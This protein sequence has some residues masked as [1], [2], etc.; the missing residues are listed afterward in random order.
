[1]N[2]STVRRMTSSYHDRQNPMRNEYGGFSARLFAMIFLIGLVI[3]VG[4]GLGI[5]AYKKYGELTPPVIEVT[6]VPRGIGIAPVTLRFRVSD[7]GSG[8]DQVVLRAQ[9]RGRERQLISR[10]L[11]GALTADEEFSFTGTKSNFQEGVLR[12]EIIAFDRSFWSNR[13]ER[14]VELS[15]DYRKPRIEVVTTQH[16][17]RRGGS[18]LVAYRA[19]DENLALSGIKIGTKVFLGFRAQSFDPAFEDPNLYMAFYG[20]D[21]STTAETPPIKAFAEDQAG[22]SASTDFYNK[23]LDRSTREVTQMISEEFLRGGMTRLFEQYGSRLADSFQEMDSDPFLSDLDPLVKRFKVVNERLR[24]SDQIFIRDAVTSAPRFDSYINQ[25][26]L[27]PPGTTIGQFGDLITYRYQDE[28]IG[29]TRQLG[30]T[31]TPYA[32]ASEVLAANGG[33]VS[34]AE[35]HGSYGRVVIIDHGLGI[36]SIYSNLEDLKVHRG[37]TVSRGQAI[38]LMGSSGFALKPGAYIE[39][40]V[41]GVTVDPLE[42]WDANWFNQHVIAKLDDVKRSLGIPITKRL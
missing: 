17:A 33:V 13:A 8:L 12:L 28:T 25:F 36:S 24:T 39:M 34:L 30:I 21:L 16:N 19:F 20:L 11:K 32:G 9:Q 35:T 31:L 37:E 40:R 27:K 26:F 4:Y 1:M 38:G 42:W 18:Q 23:I 3:V 22:N 2:S 6:E 5:K 41:H 15:V 29:T 7:P 14:V 10:K